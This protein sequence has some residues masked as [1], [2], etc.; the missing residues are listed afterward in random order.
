VLYK[1]IVRLEVFK[2]VVLVQDGGAKDD[3]F[4]LLMVDDKRAVLVAQGSMSLNAPGGSS[5]LKLQSFRNQL[6]KAPNIRSREL[7]FCAPGAFTGNVLGSGRFDP[8]WFV[9]PTWRRPTAPP[10]RPRHRH[11]PVKAGR[12][13]SHPDR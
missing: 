4:A 7:H 8:Q 1:S 12:P 3:L 9:P 2:K 10:C 6:D 13:W 11:E 5:M